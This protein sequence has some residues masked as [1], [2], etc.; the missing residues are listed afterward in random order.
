MCLSCKGS[1]VIPLKSKIFE[2][3][4]EL[5]INGDIA[6]GLKVSDGKIMLSCKDCNN[7]GSPLDKN[8]FLPIN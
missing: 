7:F 4:A 8:K 3:D 1:N 5:S 6:E 2:A